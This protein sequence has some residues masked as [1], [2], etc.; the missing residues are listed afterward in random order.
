MYLFVPYINKMLLA[1]SKEEYKRLLLIMFIVFSLIPTLYK[2]TPFGYSDL[3][4][5][6]CVYSF[7]AYI[8]IFECKL[9]NFKSSR[10]FSIVA[11]LVITNFILVILI[12]L[13]TIYRIY[14]GGIGPYY[15]YSMN[16]VLTLFISLLIFLGFKN[17][18]IKS[19]KLIN[20]IG[21]STFG[22]YLLH[23]HR[24][25][26]FII[27]TKIFHNSDFSND[28]MLPLRIIVEVILVFIVCSLVEYARSDVIEPLYMNKIKKRFDK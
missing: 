9:D 27:W 15:F 17:L 12:D 8:R 24:I 11:L 1:L 26:R 25:S 28:S 5:F 14:I 6:I 3:V 10:I 18:K 13:A 23:D 4:W 16:K 2:D 22:V 7:G 19:S 21:A 20:T